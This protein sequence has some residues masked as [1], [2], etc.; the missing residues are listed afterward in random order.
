MKITISNKTFE[1]S[2]ED[3]EANPEEIKLEFD[4]TLRTQ[5]EE[6][7]FVENQKTLAR[8]EGAQKALRTKA[9]ELGLD[10]EGS[11]RNIDDV[12][13]AYSKKILED[14]KIEPAEQLKKI[15]LSLDEKEV[16]LQNALARVGQGETEFKSYKNQNILDTYLDSAIPSNTKLA[17]EDMKLILKS[18]IKFDFDENGSIVALDNQGNVMKDTVTANPR[19]AKDVV[20]SFFQDNQSYLKGNDGGSGEGDSQSKGTKKTLD[21]FIEEQQA[22]NVKLNSPEFTKA[23]EDQTAAGLIDVD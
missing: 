16:A 1:V 6:S 23:L 20:N 4:G 12:F 14:A 7:T 15:Q 18:K 13:K 9:D 3:F 17:K 8:T 19:L 5:E 2:K 10:I 21:K 22:K 11:K